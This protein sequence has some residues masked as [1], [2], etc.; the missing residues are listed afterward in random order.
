M[1]RLARVRRVIEH[2]IEKWHAHLRGDEH[3]ARRQ[4]PPAR[5]GEAAS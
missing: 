4:L 3:V 1:L 2:V 5:L